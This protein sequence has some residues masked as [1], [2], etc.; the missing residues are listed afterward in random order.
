[1]EKLNSQY[2][3]FRYCTC[4]QKSSRV[5]YEIDDG[6]Q[7]EHGDY[8][9]TEDHNVFLQVPIPSRVHEELGGG[10]QTSIVVAAAGQT[11]SKETEQIIS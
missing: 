3:E 2:S 8:D 4:R 9:N 10:Y 1:M 6:Y 11:D 7:E 5:T